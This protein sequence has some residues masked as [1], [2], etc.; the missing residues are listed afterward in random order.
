[1]SNDCE[2][3]TPI[4]INATTAIHNVL[5]IK[6]TR[7]RKLVFFLICIVFF[8]S[9]VR[10]MPGQQQDIWFTGFLCTLRKFNNKSVWTLD[11]CDK[12]PRHSIAAPIV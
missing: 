7:T 10:V 4:Y 2:Q 3:I 11:L 9:V 6:G 5:V 1:M 12:L 8:T